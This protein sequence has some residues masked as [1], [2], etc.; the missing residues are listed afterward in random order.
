MCLIEG[1]PICFSIFE[2]AYIYIASLGLR[3]LGSS[4]FF[5]F[6]GHE[7]MKVVA[8]ANQKGGV[9]K[10]TSVVNIACRLASSG[11]RVLV[12]D[13]VFQAETRICRVA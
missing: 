13:I 8:V 12:V 6:K 4:V 3:L 1:F 7:R 11:V 10:T 5:I 9:G 2:K